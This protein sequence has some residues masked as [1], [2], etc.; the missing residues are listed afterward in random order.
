MNQQNQQTT[1]HNTCA[2]GKPQYK[3]GHNIATDFLLTFPTFFEI[4]HKMICIGT[5]HKRD[6]MHTTLMYQL[7]WFR[8]VIGDFQN[9]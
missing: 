1:N 5:V 2:F 9:A 7:L 4:F 8:M 3:R 6:E